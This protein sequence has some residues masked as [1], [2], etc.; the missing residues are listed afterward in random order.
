MVCRKLSIEVKEIV[1]RRWV[2][3]TAGALVS[4]AIEGGGCSKKDGKAE[5]EVP[6]ERQGEMKL[7]MVYQVSY[8]VQR[9]CLSFAVAV[10]RRCGQRAAQG[11]V[12]SSR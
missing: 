11:E 5:R 4:K 6:A 2:R 1:G 8:S 9:H 3:E 12:A 7:E 10:Q